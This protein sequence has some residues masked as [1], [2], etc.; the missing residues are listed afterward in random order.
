MCT[1]IAQQAQLEGLVPECVHGQC[2]S[3]MVHASC[4]IVQ[5]LLC[6]AG[7]AAGAVQISATAGLTPLEQVPTQVCFIALPRYALADS[8][9]D[10]RLDCSH[11]ACIPCCLVFGKE[12]VHQCVVRQVSSTAHVKHSSGA[13]C[14]TH[15]SCAARHLH[16]LLACML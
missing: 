4:C 15:S 7:L 5:A 6:R 16:V 8:N 3:I 9:L 12:G 10:P 14:A 11:H 2:A 13:S 1:N